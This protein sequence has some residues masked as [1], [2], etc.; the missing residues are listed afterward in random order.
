MSHTNYY[1]L[2]LKNLVGQHTQIIL[3]SAV[4]SNAESIANWLVEGEKEIITGGDLSPTFRSL[5]FV[6]WTT[7][8]GRLE[9]VNSSNPKSPRVLCSSDPGTG[10][11]KIEE[12]ENRKKE[13]FLKKMMENKLLYIWD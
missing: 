13:Y 9:F 11:F 5:A 3:I 8:L 6:S 7:I 10:K 2:T 12:K 1:Y 4:I